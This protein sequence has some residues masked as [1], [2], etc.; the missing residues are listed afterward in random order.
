VVINFSVISMME[1]IK[2]FLVPDLCRANS[3]K[4]ILRYAFSAN[5]TEVVP[6]YI[7]V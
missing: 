1:L 6:I 2:L 7:P 5:F 3:K 4:I